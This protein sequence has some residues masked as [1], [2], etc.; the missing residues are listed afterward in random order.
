MGWGE[1]GTAYNGSYP[2]P[3]EVGGVWVIRWPKHMKRKDVP[4]DATPVE[5]E[6][7][8]GKEVKAATRRRSKRA[9]H[10]KT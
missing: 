2:W 10:A 1:D 4:L 3:R 7:G 8:E 6:A 5:D 9:R